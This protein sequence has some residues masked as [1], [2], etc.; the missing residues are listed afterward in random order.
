MFLYRSYQC[1]KHLSK[2]DSTEIKTIADIGLVN[3]KGDL[4]ETCILKNPTIVGVPELETYKAWKWIGARNCD[5]GSDFRGTC[6]AL[7]KGFW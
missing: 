3:S 4:E 5:S 1:A 2:G 6:S 7:S